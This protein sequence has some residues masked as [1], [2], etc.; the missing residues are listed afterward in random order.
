MNNDIFWG[1][2]FVVAGIFFVYLIIKPEKTK[3]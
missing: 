2:F 1:V 3:K